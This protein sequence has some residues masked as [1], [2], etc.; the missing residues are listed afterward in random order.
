MGGAGHGAELGVGAVE[1]VRDEVVRSHP[2]E[3]ARSRLVALSLLVLL[4]SGC[5]SGVVPYSGFMGDYV[6][7]C[8]R[9]ALALRVRSAEELRTAEIELV[10][11]VQVQ[12]G[13]EVDP[14]IEEIEAITTVNSD[15][16]Y[17]WTCIVEVSTESQTFTARIT[18]FAPRG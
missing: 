17:S 11:Y 13:P 6:N 10:D 8:G 14:S 7:A 5:A 3:Q 1:S 15:E 18:E 9:I 4:T 16:S 2:E 12:A